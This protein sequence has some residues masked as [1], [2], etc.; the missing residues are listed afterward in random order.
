[1]PSKSQSAESH[2]GLIVSLVIFVLLAIVLGVTT[3]TGYSGQAQLEQ[4]KVKADQEA[5]SAK[6]A[7]DEALLGLATYRLAATG[8]AKDVEDV[9]G[10]KDRMQDKFKEAISKIKSTGLTWNDTKTAF[11]GS[12]AAR[13][14]QLNEQVADLQTQLAKAKK[15]AEDSIASM[16]GELE[17]TQKGKKALQDDL[18]KIEGDY[19]ALA[20]KREQE[21]K[22]YRQELDALTKQIGGDRKKANETKEDTE[23]Q[24]AGLNRKLKELRTSYDRVS[25]EIKPVNLLDHAKSLGQVVAIGTEG[26]NV[27]INLGTSDNIQPQLTFSVF[28][29]GSFRANRSPKA[30]IEVLAAVQPHLSR[31]HITWL[32]DRGRDPI[33]PGDQLYNPAW[34]PNRKTH[35]AIAGLL[36]LTGDAN[37]TLGEAI[38]D[39]QEFLRS[40]P[41]Q[42][43]VVD[44]YEDLRDGAIKG[45]IGYQT[46]YLV[47]GTPAEFD[48]NSALVSGVPEIDRKSKINDLRGQM[49]EMA[50]LKGVQILNSRQFLAL[51][52]FQLPRAVR[53]LDYG[54]ATYGGSSALPR[55]TFQQKQSDD[56]APTKPAAKPKKA[57]PAKKK[58]VDDDDDN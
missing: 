56:T 45:E 52:G 41:R 26:D 39:Q 16:K 46:T 34:S 12:Y 27:Y 2:T 57:A 29:N 17:D 13:M 53:E 44:S 36:N 5:T 54:G 6:T 49:Q 51:T 42:N 35:I 58:P 28:S 23:K 10:L 31:A 14:K 19:K 33:V 7:R 1:M 38:R 22:K 37:P 43:M 20:D 25:A 18:A 30:S 50:R 32:R 47:L 11:D 24:I 8:D 40:A 15:D 3:Y 21:F 48:S 4:A 55:D 9:K